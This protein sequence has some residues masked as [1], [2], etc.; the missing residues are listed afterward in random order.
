MEKE[1]QSRQA[2]LTQF[3]NEVCCPSPTTPLRSAIA[4]GLLNCLTL[5]EA[6][7]LALAEP[8]PERRLREKLLKLLVERGQHEPSVVFD[9]AVENLIGAFVDS[10]YPRSETFAYFL[11]RLCACMPRDGR[12]TIIETFLQ[13]TQP[14]VRRRAYKL[15]LEDW[16]DEWKVAVEKAWAE[17]HES[18]CALVIVEHFAPEYL[19]VHID[20]LVDDLPDLA[21]VGRLYLRACSN[22]PGLLRKLRQLDGITYAYV[23][24]RLSVPISSRVAGELLREHSLDGRLGILAWSLGRLGHWPLLVQLSKEV[25]GIEDR[26]QQQR[27]NFL[28]PATGRA[29]A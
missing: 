29:N 18:E 9:S 12:R 20:Q 1:S 11:E 15:L 19:V 21:S 25:R 2:Y 26:I 4:G 27:L 14:R 24:A 16:T 13:S 3:W 10:D 7:D 22:T 28:A 17:W 6:I 5:G 23:S 8:L